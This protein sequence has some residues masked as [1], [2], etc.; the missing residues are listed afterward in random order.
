MAASVKFTDDGLDCCVL[1]KTWSARWRVRALATLVVFLVE[2]EAF[3][4][5]CWVWVV[6]HVLRHTVL[7][8]VVF[9]VSWQAA[10]RI[11]LQPVLRTASPSPPSGARHT[12]HSPSCVERGRAWSSS[13]ATVFF[14]TSQC[15][16]AP[17]RSELRHSTSFSRA[18]EDMGQ[19]RA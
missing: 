2:R 9:A 1:Q 12:A 17:A 11:L 4:R 19:P 6:Q 3:S 15:Q 5:P 13:S 8:G 7:Q 10:L 18:T 16:L 14:G